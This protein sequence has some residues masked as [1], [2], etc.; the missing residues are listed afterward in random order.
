MKA[1]CANGSQCWVRN[2]KGPKQIYLHHFGGIEE[3]EKKNENG[4]ERDLESPG[5]VVQKISQDEDWQS[6]GSF[7]SFLLP[8]WGPKALCI[9][10]SKMVQRLFW[11][12]WHRNSCALVSKLF[13][14]LMGSTFRLRQYRNALLDGIKFRWK[15]EHLNRLYVN[16]LI[17]LT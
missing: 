15:L 3:A 13:D 14:V 17:S 11:T 5:T 8:L 10:V 16:W 12:P 2:M 7:V 9:W 4:K 6:P 1:E